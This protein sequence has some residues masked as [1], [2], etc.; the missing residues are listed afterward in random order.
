MVVVSSL[1]MPYSDIKRENSFNGR[2]DADFTI[3]FQDVGFAYPG[4]ASVQVLENFNLEVK[5]GEVVA[6]VGPSGGGKSTVVKLLQRFYQATEGMISI[7]DN[8]IFAFDNEFYRRLVSI[9]SQEPTLYSS[10]IAENIAYGTGLVKEKH[11][12]NFD[13]WYTR[14]MPTYSDDEKSKG[15]PVEIL[16]AAR[17]ANA[18]EF[19]MAMPQGYHTEIGNKGTQL[20][21]GQKQRVAIARALVRQP[22]ILLLDEV[23]VCVCVCV[24][25]FEFVCARVCAVVETYS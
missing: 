10:S 20:S 15:I 11:K 4:R 18:H 16:D 2:A 7:K 22:R 5:S 9:V 3:S 1:D 12:D 13:T 25:V 6:L 8:D 17:L 19:I 23:R 21:G 14:E 24:C